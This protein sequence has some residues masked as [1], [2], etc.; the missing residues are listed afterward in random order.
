MSHEHEEDLSLARIEYYETRHRRDG[1]TIS[2]LIRE[3]TF[4]EKRT[5]VLCVALAKAVMRAELAE[6]QQESD[7]RAAASG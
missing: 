5:E 2:Q 4:L 1:Q 3:K 7:E 6:A